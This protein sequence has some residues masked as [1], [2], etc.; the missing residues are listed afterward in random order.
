MYN[1]LESYYATVIACQ[2][3]FDV[4]VTEALKTFDMIKEI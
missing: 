1:A 4:G 3:K 2:Y